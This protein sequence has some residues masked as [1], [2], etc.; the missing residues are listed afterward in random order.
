MKVKRINDYTLQVMLQKDELTERGIGMM[1]LMGNQQQME[2]FFQTVLDEV[3]PQHQFSMDQTVLFQVMPTNDGIQLTITKHDGD[4]TDQDVQEQAAENISRFLQN[5]LRGHDFD[6]N[7][8]RSHG[9]DASEQTHDDADEIAAALN[10][11]DVK[12]YT[13]VV[14]FDSFEDFVALAKVIDTSN[15]AADLYQEGHHYIL[16]VTFFENG[17]LSPE[18]VKDRLAVIYEYAS[19]SKLEAMVV[20]E[21]GHRVMEHAA[22]ELARHYFS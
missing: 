10:D 14:K 6:K 11:P 5:E 21:H 9:A 19:P 12:K 13:R 3:D 2:D 7:D 16:V 20:A 17:E 15:M 22:F 1:G 18:S 8:Q 4:V